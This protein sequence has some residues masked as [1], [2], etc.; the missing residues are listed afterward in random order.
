MHDAAG[1]RRA[2][3]SRHLEGDVERRVHRQRA[4]GETHAQRLA[5]QT[6]GDQI[7]GTAVFPDVVDGQHIAV[8]EGA[9]GAG[10]GFKREPA[11]GGVR[12]VGQQQLD[13]DVAPESHVAR[14]PHFA[15][16][17]GADSPLERVGADPIAG[18]R[19]P[20]LAGDLP[21]EGLERRRGEEGAR[22][23]RGG[24][25]GGNLV[26]QAGIGA[27][28]ALEKVPTQPYGLLDRRRE[29]FFETM[30]AVSGH[31]PR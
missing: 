6:L 21:R 13:G 24:Q 7:W 19:T 22:L 2:K 25:Q 18:L 26:P 9:G 4:A 8:I 30:P 5:V 11:S 17:A 23:L 16:P 20:P 28:M 12:R 3:P 31:G 27:T 14:A 15:H 29:D 10:L 1:V